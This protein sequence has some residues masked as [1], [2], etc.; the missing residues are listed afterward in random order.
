MTTIE[1]TPGPWRQSWQFIVAPDPNGIHPD[2]YIA[3]IAEE[4]S[5]GRIA[6]P[7][8][9]KANGQVIVAAPALLAALKG[10]IDYAESEAYSLEKLKD[11]PEAEVEAER[12]W[13]AVEA[14]RTAIAL[15]TD[16]RPPSGITD[17]R[18]AGIS[19]YSV[20]LLYPDYANDS[21]TE[22]YYGLVE[23]ADPDEAI[24][25]AQRQAAASLDGVEMEPDDFTPLLVTKGHHAS[26]SLFN[27]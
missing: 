14:G 18:P 1:H 3:E 25:L 11:S 20:L 26:E 16:V 17:A 21:G 22:T 4:D 6:S 19:P 8:Q 15:A 12:A 23:A 13:K 24:E 5:E 2:I 7:E 9:Q 27:K 10:V